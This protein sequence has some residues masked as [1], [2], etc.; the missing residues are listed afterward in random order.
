VK[1]ILEQIFRWECP[2]CNHTNYSQPVK[3]EVDPA[4]KED[5]LR[6]QLGINEWDPLPDDFDQYVLMG[7]PQEVV[8][9]ECFEILEAETPHHE[10]A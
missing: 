2:S 9:G 8:C 1:A 4:Q 6:E 3:Q 5:E 7:P 10:D